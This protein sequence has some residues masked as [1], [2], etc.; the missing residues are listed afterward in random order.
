MRAGRLLASGV[1]AAACA[2]SGDT[3]IEIDVH[4]PVGVG[5]ATEL[6]LYLGQTSAAPPVA[7]PIQTQHSAQKVPALLYRR[8]PHN[9]GDRVAL[10][11][12]KSDY[13]FYFQAGGTDQPSAIAIVAAVAV[14]ADNAPVALGVLTDLAV[15]DPGHVYR[16]PVTL[17]PAADLAHDPTNAAGTTGVEL[18]PDEAPGHFAEAC[19]R[20]A[21]A[22]VGSDILFV[23]DEADPDCDS[24]ITN[25]C[26]ANAFDATTQAEVPPT[27]FTCTGERTA[28]VMENGNTVDRTICEAGAPACVDGKGSDGCGGSAYCMQNAVCEACSDPADTAC[29][30]GV[31]GAVVVHCTFGAAPDP[32]DHT[33]VD[34]CGHSADVPAIVTHDF[35]NLALLQP[36][37]QLGPGGTFGSGS[38]GLAV[39]DTVVKASGS[40]A[41]LAVPAST[42]DGLLFGTLKQGPGTRGVAVPFRAEVQVIADCDADAVTQCVVDGPTDDNAFLDCLKSAP[43]PGDGLPPGA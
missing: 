30:L 37:G 21:Q 15:A 9:R 11:P 34:L 32:V 38:A 24:F 35:G 1:L 3:G 14:T 25:E 2:H 29:M 22:G 23:N 26:D 20:I 43:P 18:W 41:A 33:Q 40:L 5:S 6:V 4:V 17:V 12:G 10:T 7:E 31:A 8:D 13:V 42:A 28:S 27:K 39:G 36:D 19:A 16:Y